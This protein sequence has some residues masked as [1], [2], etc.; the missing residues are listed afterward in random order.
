MH[1]LMTAVRTA[2][3]ILVA[4]VFARAKTYTNPVL[5]NDL[6]DID[7]FRV[8]DTYYYSAS[9]MA[10]SPGAPILQS[11]DLVNWEYIGHSVPRLDFGDPESYSL[12][13]GKQA[14]VR[15]IWASSMRYRPSDGNWYWIGCVDFNKTYVY[16][17]SDVTGDWSLHQTIDNCYYDCGLL[18]EDDSIYVAYGNT[19]I[20][21]AELNQDFS[22]K[23]TQRVFE[24]SFYIEGSRLYKINGTY[25]IL[26]TE[27][28]SWEWTLK[29][30]GNDIWGPYQEYILANQVE[31]P[32][33]GSGYPHQGGIV[34]TPDGKWYYLAFIDDYPGGRCPVLAPIHFEAGWPTLDSQQGFA[35]ANLYP[36]DPA[37]VPGVTGT[38]KFEGPMLNP[39][40]E[41]NH[42]PVKSAFSFADDGG[43]VLDTATVTKDLFHAQNTLTHRILGPASAAIIE[44]DVKDMRA[45]DRAGL[46]LFRDNMAYISYQDSKISL[47]RNLSLDADW[48]T[49]STGF[50]EQSVDVPEDQHSIWFKLHANIAPES[51]KK[52]TFYYSTDGND[53]KQLGT[54]Y[55]MNTTYYFFIG[56]RWGIFNF[57]TE[58]LGG[59]VTVES[60]TQTAG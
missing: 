56:Y 54:P 4:T 46:A 24:G 1:K 60:F 41:W 55:V 35:I 25:Y 22:E 15:G 5:W 58:E 10:F 13:D 18:F 50:V 39:Q 44:L 43:L 57:A 16:S 40:W 11:H 9:T 19:N 38:D 37:P 27:P 59:R 48:N 6:A 51:N 20:S 30:V 21:V 23:R 31:S 2:A 33:P 45:G 8:N 47:W 3:L 32:T 28:A 53:F 12:E 17:A 7:V 36:A 42:N 14:Y 34:D 29:S 52:G 26:T 49:L